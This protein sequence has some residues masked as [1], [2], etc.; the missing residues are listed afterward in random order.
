MTTYSIPILKNK[1]KL[2]IKKVLGDYMN[3]WNRKDLIAFE[4]TFHFPH[5]RL[6]SGKMRVL[7]KPG[8]QTLESL[9]S[10]ADK[11]WHHSKWTRRRII[12]VSGEKVHVAT[13]FTRYKEDG[14]VIGVFD[15]LYILTKEDGRWGVKMRSSYAQ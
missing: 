7:E 12:H 6:A 13:Q 11:N 5:Y 4:A 8:L 14:S 3:A 1:I 9:Y 2:E 10:R 15:S